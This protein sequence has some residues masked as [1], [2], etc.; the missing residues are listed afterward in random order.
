MEK[1]ICSAIYLPEY[2]TPVHGPKNITSGLVMCGRR[3]HDIISQFVALTGTSLPAM[4]EQG[5]ITT[6]NRFV[7][8]E[9]ACD[10]AYNADQIKD[11]SGKYGLELYSEEI[12]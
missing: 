5:F 10:I 2:S 9:E 6:E 4:H 12:Y 7:G 1:I 8:R 3:H 11:K